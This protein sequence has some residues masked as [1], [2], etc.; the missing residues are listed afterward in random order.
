MNRWS[1]LSRWPCQWAFLLVLLA[2]ALLLL[3]RAAQGPVL[4]T[5]LSALLPQGRQVAAAELLAE[6]QG[7]RL[8]NQ[9]LVM[10]AGAPQAGQAVAMARQL[11]AAWQASGLFAEVRAEFL[12]DLAGLHAEARRLQ[13]ALLPDEVVQRLQADPVGYFRQRAIDLSSPFGAPSLL[14]ADQDWLGFGRFLAGKAVRGSG[15]QWDMRT[16]T[17][18]SQDGGQVW[19][20]VQA[21]LPDDS[22]VAHVDTALLPLLARTRQQAAGAGVQTLFAGGA[23]FSAEGRAAGEQEARLMSAAGIA[24]TLLLLFVVVRSIRVLAVLLPVAAG[25]LC[26]LAGCL[27]FFDSVHILTLVIGTSLVGVLIDLPLHWMAPALLVSGWRPAPAMRQVLPAYALSLFVTVSGYLV[28][29]LAPL[30]VLQQTALFSAFALAGACLASAL[31]L[32]VLFR[33]WQPR[34]AG[35]VAAAVARIMAA[36]GA[37]RGCRLCWLLGL[38]I[39]LSGLA[40]ANWHDDIRQWISVSPQWLQQMQAVGRLGGSMAGGRFLVLEAD[41]DDALLGRDAE[42]AARLQ[43]LVADGQLAGFQSLSQWVQPRARQAALRQWL[44]GLAEQ[45]QAWAPLRA[46]GVPDQ[47][48]R[49]ALLQLAASAPVGLAESLS[50]ELGRAWQALYLGQLDDPARPGQRRVAAMLRLDGL[51]DPAVLQDLLAQQPGL[52][53]VDRPARLN[54]LFRETRDSAIRLKLAS[55][56]GAALLLWLMLGWR[57]GTRVLAVPLAAAAATVALQSWL[58]LPVTLFSVFGL[59]LVSAIA[60]DYAVYAQ[61]DSQAPAGR[62]AGML[63]AALTSM[64]SFALLGLSSTPAVAGFG[65]TVTIGIFLSLIFSSWLLDQPGDAQ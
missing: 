17:L 28:L 8:L 35:W 10:L 1:A 27:L 43:R 15:V 18:Q 37:W 36:T 47:A 63:L 65:M 54:Q 40:R 21:R 23:I 30:P 46:L 41:D 49:A 6:A 56:A 60:I 59:L 45:P 58:G 38:A 31:W 16:G 25:M 52:R 24:L 64:I 4:E 3:M 12:P 32:P 33:G 13:L 57:R 26:G 51:S 42:V 2:G 5:G 20:W 34:P 48:V 53:M 61:G 7:D 11:A 14:P 22:H 44:A 19:V 9:Q 50:G 39:L 55:Y 62:M 29:W